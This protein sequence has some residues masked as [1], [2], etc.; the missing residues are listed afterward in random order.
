MGLFC[1]TWLKIR[2]CSGLARSQKQ[3]LSVKLT[4]RSGFNERFETRRDETSSN[5]TKPRSVRFHTSTSVDMRQRQRDNDIGT[6][7]AGTGPKFLSLLSKMTNLD[8][9]RV[10]ETLNGYRN[11]FGPIGC[12]NL[13]SYCRD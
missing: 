4:Q 5:K 10:V 3:L 12:G 1:K 6:C 7:R 13:L 9:A 2:T 11:L 8:F